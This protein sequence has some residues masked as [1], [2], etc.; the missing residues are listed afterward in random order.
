MKLVKAFAIL[1]VPLLLS[2]FMTVMPVSAHSPKYFTV[3]GYLYHDQNPPPSGPFI[4]N[5][6][7]WDGKILYLAG[8]DLGYFFGGISGT[9]FTDWAWTIHGFDPTAGTWQWAIMNYLETFSSVTITLPDKSTVT[10]GLTMSFIGPI[11]TSPGNGWY[12]V[13]LMI[14]SGT[15]ALAS[16]HGEG[17]AWQSPWVPHDVGSEHYI[18]TVHFDS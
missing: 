6:F 2:S 18:M 7:N 14:I 9:A 5:V 16:L 11:S 13:Q 4:T 8:T 1:L 3:A 15:G 10:G 17:I 12:V